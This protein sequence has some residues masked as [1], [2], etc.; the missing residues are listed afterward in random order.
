MFKIFVA[1]PHKSPEVANVL[2]N[3][4]DK[5]I[6]FLQTFQEERDDP[7]FKIEKNNAIE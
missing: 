7:L 6:A 5:I 1:N 4:R 3:N 2:F